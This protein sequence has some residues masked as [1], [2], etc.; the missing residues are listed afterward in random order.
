[1]KR[2]ICIRHGFFA[3]L[4]LVGLLLPAGAQAEESGRLAGID[5]ALEASAL[6]QAEQAAIRT[7]AAAAIQAGLPAE[8]VAIIVT[9][10]L[11]RGVDGATIGRFLDAGQQATGAGLSAGPVLDR[12]E[13]GLAKGVA[14]DRIAAASTGLAEKM[15][16]AR[17]IVD[18]LIGRG[19]K[20]KRNTERDSA[21]GSSARALEKGIVPEDMA[22]LGMAVRNR[23]GSL[24]LFA[25]AA[26]TTTYFAGS[27]MSPATAARLVRHAVEKGFTMGDLDNMI[28]QMD[29]EL[30]RGAGAEDAAARMDRDTMQHDRERG[31]QDMTIERGRGAGSGVGG[32]RR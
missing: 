17:P 5:Q 18:D 27:G 1:M 11:G 21:I 25:R 10:G 29:A 26:D 6:P 2:T 14:P 28:K 3:A 8:D 4:L 32:R 19:L 23:G 13:Q 12:I 15:Q 24:A 20:P 7:R 31:R 9:R 30:R 22:A 16:A